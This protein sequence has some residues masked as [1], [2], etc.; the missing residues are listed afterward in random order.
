MKLPVSIEE[1]ALTDLEE[2]V[3]LSA[4][5]KSCAENI[6]H[7]TDIVKKSVK[8]EYPDFV[9]KNYERTEEALDNI[10][11]IISNATEELTELAE[12][13]VKYYEKIRRIEGV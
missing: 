2:L 11:H 13:A 10:S 9:S 6:C 8:L 12:S 3:R 7:S 1:Y 5:V 4:V